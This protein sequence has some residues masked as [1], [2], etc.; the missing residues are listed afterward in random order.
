MMK[1]LEFLDINKVT[2]FP[3]IDHVSDYLK[4]KCSDKE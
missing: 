1:D 2:L 4:S 3:D